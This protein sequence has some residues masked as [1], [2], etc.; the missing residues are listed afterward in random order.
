MWGRNNKIRLRGREG[1]NFDD[2]RVIEYFVKD[3]FFGLEG[4]EIFFNI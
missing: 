1:L 4:F 2:Y 3:F